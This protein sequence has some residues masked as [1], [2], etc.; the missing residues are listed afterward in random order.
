MINYGDNYCINCNMNGHYYYNCKKPSL[1]S[2]IIAVR[3]KDTH[4]ECCEDHLSEEDSK[5]ELQFLM[6]KRKHT[7]GFIDFVSTQ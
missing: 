4:T 5:K 2:G 7:F 6:V 1:S 3:L